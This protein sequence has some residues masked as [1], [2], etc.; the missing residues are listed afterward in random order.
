M[1][2]KDIGYELLDVKEIVR[3]VAKYGVVVTVRRD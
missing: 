3:A 2:A 1:D